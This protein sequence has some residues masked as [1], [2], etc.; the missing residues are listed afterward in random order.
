[1]KEQKPG[2]DRRNKNH[3]ETIDV[4]GKKRFATPSFKEIA[5]ELKRRESTTEIKMLQKIS[6]KKQSAS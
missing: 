6:N 1:M 2:N 5:E 3:K 4:V